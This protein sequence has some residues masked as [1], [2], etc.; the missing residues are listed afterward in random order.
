[1]SGPCIALEVTSGRHGDLTPTKFRELIGPSD[2]VSYS[3]C[4]Y[5]YEDWYCHLFYYYW[6]RVSLYSTTTTNPPPPLFSSQV[7][8]QELRP[9]SL[10]AKFGSDRVRNA[11]HCSDLP[12]DGPLEVTLILFYSAISSFVDLYCR[13]IYI[14]HIINYIWIKNCHLQYDYFYCIM[15][16]VFRLNISLR[17]YSDPRSL[18]ALGQACERQ[19]VTSQLV[20]SRSYISSGSGT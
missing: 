18:S 11:L 19:V 10:R 6:Y 7:V 8:A 16:V 3:N 2:P 15:Y 14:D 17:S 20:C 13:F 1:M 12:E 9:T 4:F 5:F